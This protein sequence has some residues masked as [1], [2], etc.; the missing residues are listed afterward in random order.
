M[1]VILAGRFV[2]CT[3]ARPLINAQFVWS[4]VASLLFYL[5]LGKPSGN[6]DAR[7]W[8]VLLYLGLV[9]TLF[10][11]FVAMWGT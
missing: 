4:A 11:Y 6:V 1:Q 3:A 5:L 7:A 10:C 9:G 2:K 8:A